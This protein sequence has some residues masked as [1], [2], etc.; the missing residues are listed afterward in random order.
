MGD[1]VMHAATVSSN[2]NDW[3]TPPEFYAA[4]DAEFRFTLD[5]CATVSNAKA[6][7]FF[8]AEEDGLAQRWAPHR[9]FMNPP[10]W[11]SGDR[12]VDRQSL[13]GVPGWRHGR[14]PHPISHR[15]SLVASVHPSE[16]RGALREGTYPLRRRLGPRAV[17][18]VHRHLS[19]PRRY[20]YLSRLRPPQ[21]GTHRRSLLLQLLPPTRLPRPE[22]V[23]MREDAHTRGRRLLVEGRL[24]VRRVSDGHIVASCRGDSGVIHT[25]SG[26]ARGFACS[27]PAFRTCAHIVAL[28]LVTLLPTRGPGP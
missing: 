8:S 4:L 12:P 21:P 1:R 14:V 20:G 28:S 24:I 25:V 11:P 27:C 16:G 7:A 3:P 18:I 17:P 23:S 6:P 13:G 5:P 15:H 10:L 22:A 2:S 19:A 26:D 9:V